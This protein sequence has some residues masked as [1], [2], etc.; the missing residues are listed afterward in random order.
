MTAQKK[1]IVLISE[2]T[3]GGTRKHILDLINGIDK[4][5]FELTFI[6]SLKR[7]DETFLNSLKD[8]NNSGIK[9]IEVPMIREINLISDF[10]CFLK[11][12]FLLKKIKPNLIHL[13]ASK[14]GVLGRA[15]AY[16]LGIQNIV[17]N[18][19]G[20][21]FHRFR[22]K[23]GKFY[24]FIEKLFAFENVH[25]IGVSKYSTKL[26]KQYL[27]IDDSKNH[28]IYNGIEPSAI[29][30]S[31]LLKSEDK[32]K[33]LWP[34]FFFSEK[35]HL[36]FIEGILAAGGLD[37][38]IL[39]SLAGTGI[40]MNNIEELIG[41]YNLS[42]SF[43]FLGFR[44]DITELIDES[45][46]VILPSRYEFFPYSILESYARSKPVFATKVGAIPEI[47]EHGVSG[48]LFDFEKP[49]EFVKRLNYY[50]HNSSELRKFGEQ[51]RKIVEEYFSLKQMIE[52]TE[53]LY[54]DILK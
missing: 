6:Y 18:P 52:K 44:A 7:A 15:A 25:Y 50:A 17:F 10:Y 22:G 16:I 14:A 4:N 24:L 35:G 1:H 36:K 54:L 48:E 28:L 3:S 11:L 33:I 20:G 38:K 31:T 45:D 51:G 40:L 43:K 37:P 12:V 49:E 23:L 47:I 9:L 39:I 42:F 19:H 8:L 46:L 21:S 53:K 5:K 29:D 32:F 2:V 30:I 41:K 13:H 34:A 26:F 27:N